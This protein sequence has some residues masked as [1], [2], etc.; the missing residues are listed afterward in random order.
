MT[1]K[2][3]ELLSWNETGLKNR[4]KI[5][6]T[7]YKSSNRNRCTGQIMGG[8]SSSVRNDE[9]DYV[10]KTTEGEHKVSL[11]FLC[12]CPGDLNCSKLGCAKS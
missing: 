9:Q 3:H 4:Q 8:V 6:L 10:V 11:Q 12:I 1:T 5:V 7:N 2:T